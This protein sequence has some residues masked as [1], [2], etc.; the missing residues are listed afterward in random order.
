MGRYLLKKVPQETKGLNVLRETE[1]AFDRAIPIWAEK[2]RKDYNKKRQTFPPFMKWR[3]KDLPKS[4]TQ[5]MIAS[6]STQILTNMKNV[7]ITVCA[8][9]T[10]YNDFLTIMV[11]ELRKGGKTD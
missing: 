1:A 3:T 9:D 11:E 7:L 6:R 2:L 8:N 10:A 4:W 5:K